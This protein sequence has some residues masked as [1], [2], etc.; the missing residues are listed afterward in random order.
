LTISLDVELTGSQTPRLASTPPFFRCT[1]GQDAV[2]LAAHAGL[3]LDPWEA[4]VLRDSLNERDRS[5]RWSA[6]EVGLV[7]PRQN[8]KGAIIEARQLAALFLTG[9]DVIIYSAHKFRTAKTMYRRIRDLIRNTPDLHRLTGGKHDTAGRPIGGLYRQSNEETGIELLTGQRLNFVARSAGTG[10]GLTGNTMFFDEAYDLDPDLIADMLPLLSAVK[11]PQVWYV[12]SAGMEASEQ[13]AAVRAR[14]L[15]GDEPR[16]MYRE[17]SAPDDA[18]TDDVDAW[19]IANP[20]IGYRL[21]LEYIQLVERAGMVGDEGESRFRRERLGIWKPP[22]TVEVVIP[23]TDWTAL[24]DATPILSGPVALAVDV[25][26]DRRWCSIAAASLTESGGAHLEIG[27]HEAP[28]AAVTALLV[29]LVARWDPCAVVIDKLSPAASLIPGLE[30]AGIEA[31][32]TGAQEMAAACGGLYDAVA[33]RSISH[34]GDPLL[35][36]SLASAVKREMPSGAWAWNRR[37]NTPISPL[38]AVTLARWGLMTFGMVAKPKP[39][40]PQF[41]T[42]A[43]PVTAG[44]MTAGF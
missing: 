25:T 18:D 22:E 44:L 29:A 23:A 36:A 4:D 5:G 12:S 8:G 11:N 43:G 27:F 34:T 24:L 33:E 9:D 16:L 40:A 3:Y 2:D 39:A 37:G 30:A 21:D 1:L 13:L 7:V 15:A 14:G 28:S 10:R 38:V 17:W 35:I 32:Q 42:K 41:T 20:G 26:P 31:E 19:L 6:L